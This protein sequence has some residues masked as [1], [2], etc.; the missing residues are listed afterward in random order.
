MSASPLWADVSHAKLAASNGCECHKC[1]FA[2][3]AG[4]PQQFGTF[5]TGNDGL[6]INEGPY[7]GIIVVGEIPSFNDKRGP[8]SGRA[9]RDWKDALEKT[10]LANRRLLLVPTVHCVPSDVV[11]KANRD[12]A[13]RAC[14]PS[15]QSVL[16]KWPNLP[17]LLIGQDAMKSVGIDKKI[18]ESRGFLQEGVGG[19]PYIITYSAT[20]VMFGNIYMWGTFIED[21]RRFNRLLTKTL[22]PGL[23]PEMVRIM[24][25]LDECMNFIQ[26]NQARPLAVD[27]ETTAP[28]TNPEWGLDATRASLKT[29]AIGV[30]EESIAIAWSLADNATINYITDILTS[31]LFCKVYHNGP[32]F[33]LR[34]LE[35]YGISTAN[36]EDTR[37][38]RRAISSTSRLSLG[39]LGSLYCD[40]HAWKLDDNNDKMASS[41]KL[42]ELLLYNGYDTIV[43]ARIY[44]SMVGVLIEKRGGK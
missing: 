31:S 14:R 21:L 41:D 17:M 5:A 12:Q 9:K 8:L 30:P 25:T 16:A 39:Y 32:W 26:R 34:V 20:T 24:P 27:I 40:I 44:A 11:K 22:K 3:S 29:I 6:P 37:D 1:P 2:D 42:D 7:D 19:R 36:W 35:R 13:V 38:L 43:T 15:V 23:K 18:N 33:D 28:P 10:G 4:K